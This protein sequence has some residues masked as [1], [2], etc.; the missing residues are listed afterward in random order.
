MAS[1]KNL[2]LS[3]AISLAIVGSIVNA[4]DYSVGKREDG[5][6]EAC[7]YKSYVAA[8]ENEVVS[9]YLQP[10]ELDNFSR[11]TFINATDHVQDGKGGF[12]DI[13]A[14][15]VGQNFAYMILYSQQSQPINFTVSVYGMDDP[16]IT[17]T[18]SPTSTTS[19]ASTSTTADPT[20]T[21]DSSV[22]S[23]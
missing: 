21:E 4:K 10:C 11:I 3:L 12:M 1:Y 8:D 18:N 23:L 17:S 20:T 5:D 6:E 19:T 14:G 13:T 16:V 7:S 15:G 22:K 2:A 9:E